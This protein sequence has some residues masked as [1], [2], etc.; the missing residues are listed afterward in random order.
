[1]DIF[2][3]F[4]PQLV[5]AG[6]IIRAIFHQGIIRDIGDISRLEEFRKSQR[7]A[8][9]FKDSSGIFFDRDGTL[10]EDI[11]H[12]RDMKNLKVTKDARSLVSA[13][14]D[15]FG[16]LGIITN[17]P[18]VARGEAT[19]QEV[20]Y[21][22]AKL[23]ELLNL[24][25]GQVSAI[26][27]CTHHPDAGFDGEISSLKIT[28]RCRKPAPGLFIEATDKLLLRATKCLYIGDSIVDIQAAE[29]VGMSW[30]HLKN[31][32][33]ETHDHPEGFFGQCLTPK[34]AL[35]AIGQWKTI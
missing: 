20:I 34:E 22:N 11:G 17:Q 14:I 10:N 26:M 33:S 9:K 1:M 7:I 32:A 24:E 35:A 28:C 4:L 12:L 15:S 16:S 8:S 6:Y 31:T 13:A 30:I 29:S 18:V 3:N 19:L 23:I 21:I 25:P 27:M 5:K 2:K